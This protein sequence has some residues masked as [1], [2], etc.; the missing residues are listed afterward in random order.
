MMEIVYRDI[1]KFIQCKN[2]EKHVYVDPIKIKVD[3]KKHHIKF[4]W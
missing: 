4:K 2:V 3:K 1:N